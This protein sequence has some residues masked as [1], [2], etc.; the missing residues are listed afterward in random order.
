MWNNHVWRSSI[1]LKNHCP[2]YNKHKLVSRSLV[3]YPAPSPSHMAYIMQIIV[4]WLFHIIISC[5]LNW[6]KGHWLLSNSLHVTIIMSSKLKGN[7]N[8]LLIPLILDNLMEDDSNLDLNWKSFVVNMKK[9][10]V[11]SLIISFSSWQNTMIG[12]FPMC[13]PR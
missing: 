3:M 1:D 9:K 13:Y 5:A 11:W 4:Y 12:E 6:V 8:N 2:C 7:N 10:Y